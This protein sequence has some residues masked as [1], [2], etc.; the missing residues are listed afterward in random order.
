MT[1]QRNQHTRPNAF[2]NFL[3]AC[4]PDIPKHKSA[5]LIASEALRVSRIVSNATDTAGAKS[6]R[7]TRNRRVSGSSAGTGTPPGA[8]PRQLTYRCSTRSRISWVRPWFQNWVPM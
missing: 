2:S 6:A 5:P 4:T 7:L 3:A 1:L 8:Q